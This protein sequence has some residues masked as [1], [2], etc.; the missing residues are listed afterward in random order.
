MLGL[1]GKYVEKFH[2]M[3]E[4]RASPKLAAVRQQIGQDC[5]IN[6]FRDLT[7]EGLRIDEAEASF[8]RLMDAIISETWNSA[9]IRHVGAW[10]DV[11][12]TR[13]HRGGRPDLNEK[14]RGD[15]FDLC[16]MASLASADIFLM[17]RKFTGIG[18]NAAQRAGTRLVHSPSDLLDALS[19][20]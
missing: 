19:H 9:A 6:V 11:F 5:L 20:L 3:A 17:E 18:R 12:A 13:V 15:A 1:L 2:G 7:K 16:H 4:Q 8:R 14:H 10:V